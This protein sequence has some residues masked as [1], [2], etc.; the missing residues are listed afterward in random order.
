MEPSMRRAREQVS[1]VETA[2]KIPVVPGAQGFDPPEGESG[3]PNDGGERGSRTRWG[4]WIRRAEQ[5]EP[6]NLG[7]S[8]SSS[9]TFRQS[10]GAPVT[11]S[12]GMT[13]RWHARSA[14]WL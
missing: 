7:E 13:A 4:E 14:A 5:G 3:P 12:P 11:N 1:R 10:N 8:H 6:R 2:S 9:R